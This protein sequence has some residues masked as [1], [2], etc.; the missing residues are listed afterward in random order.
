VGA[1]EIFQVNHQIPSYFDYFALQRVVIYSLI[2]GMSRIFIV[3]I[4]HR[5]TIVTRKLKKQ[6][7]LNCNTF[8]IQTRISAKNEMAAVLALSH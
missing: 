8:R 4:G 3:D 1:K 6:K 2:I 7:N 5:P